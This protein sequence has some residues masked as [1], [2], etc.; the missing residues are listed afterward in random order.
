MPFNRIHFLVFLKINIH[1]NLVII[2]IFFRRK[3]IWQPNEPFPCKIRVSCNKLIGCLWN[4][5]DEIHFWWSFF[6]SLLYFSISFLL[7]V[8]SI[9]NA[10]LRRIGRTRLKGIW[11]GNY[12]LWGERGRRWELGRTRQG[13][14]TK[15]FVSRCRLK[16]KIRGDGGTII[17]KT[18]WTG[19]GMDRV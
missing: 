8:W 10:S 17:L 3:Y 13:Q 18:R 7:V 5:G 2:F 16:N 11:R 6:R 14:G 1:I 15:K 4:D 12:L 9:C 19:Q